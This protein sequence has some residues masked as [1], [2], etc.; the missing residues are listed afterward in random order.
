M[1]LRSVTSD[2]KTGVFARLVAIQ[3]G[4]ILR[5][6]VLPEGADPVAQSQAI[7]KEFSPYWSKLAGIQKGK[8]TA[9]S[10]LGLRFEVDAPETREM[11]QRMNI[12]LASRLSAE[13]D[14]VVLERWRLKRC[15]FRK[16]H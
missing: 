11:E 13:P 16:K 1:L 14:V 4:V 10:L 3:P 6:I 2:G 9:L 8:I 12:L 15:S 5:E 7:A